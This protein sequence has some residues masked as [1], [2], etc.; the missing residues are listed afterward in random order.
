MPLSAAA[1]CVKISQIAKGGLGQV[2]IAGQDLNLTLQNLWLHRDLKV[3]R[4]T[5]F[6]TPAGGSYGPFPLESDYQRT[7]DLFFPLPLSGSNAS[8]GQPQFLDQV[9]MEQFDMEFKDVSTTDYPYEF[10]TDLS[11]QA[12]TAATAQVSAITPGA[13]SAGWLY[14]YPQSPGNI[15]LTHRYMCSQ[16][17]ITNPAQSSTVPWFVDQDYLITATAARMMQL[18]GDSRRAEFLEEAERLLKPYL[19]MEGDEQKTVRGIKLDPRKFH[20]K[21]GLKPTKSDPF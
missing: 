7:Y 1:L 12:Q 13:T 4:V 2:S 14:I 11:L 16:P 19:I 21:R 10:A 3:N 5:Q 20:Y 18:T 8:S 9:T 6:I 15:T 17:D